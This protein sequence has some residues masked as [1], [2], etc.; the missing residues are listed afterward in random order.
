MIADGD[1]QS[2][3]HRFGTGVAEEHVVQSGRGEG[4][5]AVRQFVGAGVA[6]V[7]RRGVVHRLK[8]TCHRF[9]DFTPPV[10]G[11]DAPQARHRV[12]NLTTVATP[13]VHTGGLR[14]NPRFGLEL[15]VWREGH[16]QGFER[17]RRH[18]RMCSE[19]GVR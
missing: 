7:E 3:I 18:D 8:L 10:T 5:H 17:G 9:G 4:R 14:E 2:G 16:P 1:L 19:T 13:I 11:V 6:H 15:A 12:E